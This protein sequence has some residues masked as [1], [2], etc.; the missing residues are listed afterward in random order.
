MS[1]RY[2]R[3]IKAHKRSD[4]EQIQLN[5]GD[6]VG[7]HDAVE[8]TVAIG[9]NLTIWDEVRGWYWVQT[10]DRRYGWVPVECVAFDLM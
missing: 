7:D 8:L 2:G 6:V 3:V 10:V 1:V 9:D 5:R 4:D